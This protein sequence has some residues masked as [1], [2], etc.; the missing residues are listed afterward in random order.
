M[1]TGAIFAR[2]SCRALKWMA[3][4]GVVFTLGVGQA[5]AQ[6]PAGDTL[7]LSIKSVSIGGSTADEVTVDENSVVDVVVTLSAKLPNN[8]DDD[9][10]NVSRLTLPIDVTATNILV[11]GSE[12][13]GMAEEGDVQIDGTDL[14]TADDRDALRTF[15]EGDNTVSF[16]IELDQDPD[17]VDEKFTL[18]VALAE[19]SAA[20]NGDVNNEDETQVSIEQ[21]DGGNDSKTIEI[22]VDDDETQGYEV[23]ATDTAANITEGNEINAQVV[24]N[25]PRPPAEEVTLYVFV[26]GEDGDA[27]ELGV[28]TGATDPEVFLFNDDV[29]GDGSQ[30]IVESTIAFTVDLEDGEDS[31]GD[32]VNDT[33][34]LMLQEQ[35]VDDRREFHDRGDTDIVVN[36]V[37]MLPASDKITA[38]AYTVDEDGDKTE[39]EATMVVED[40]DPVVI[41][42]TVD[43]GE[44][45][46][47]KGE[48]LEVTLMAD[49]EQ[50]L[51]FRFPDGSNKVE[52]AM[53]D[54][55]QTAD[56]EVLALKDEDVGPE[57]LMFN[58]VTTG[59]DDDNGEATDAGGTVMGTPFSIA[60][61]GRHLAARFAEGRLGRSREDGDGRRPRGHPASYP[62][63]GHG[64]SCSW[65]ATCS[66][67]A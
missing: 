30:D 58:L 61:G 4:F 3:L 18:T 11:A 19:L 16:R 21:V 36:D 39:D 42:V 62:E 28:R 13:T 66:R 2:G 37:H 53:G 7:E 60:I 20:G 49:P 12:A 38:K 14:I 33:I 40:G 26:G 55:E 1:R 8:A 44:D 67:P 15:E 63:P 51:D 41:T 27:Y 57:M 48:P 45:G 32:R 65:G 50:G 59:T 54:D 5:A 17:A 29:D 9:E 23:E 22:T 56:I 24:L 46:Y 35:D 64:P 47:P 25:P 31:D 6:D 52:I 43:R 34:T 10:N